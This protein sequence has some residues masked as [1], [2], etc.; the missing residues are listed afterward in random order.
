VSQADDKVLVRTVLAGSNAAYA[1]LYDRYA[2][3]VRAVCYDHTKHLADAQD[4]AQDVFLRAY[5]RLGELRK[6]ERFGPWLI[7][8]TRR[9]CQEWRRQTSRERRR[10]GALEAGSTGTGDTTGHTENGQLLRLI[11]ML[12]ENERLALHAFYL[13]SQSVEDARGVLGLS[14]SGFY[15]VLERARNRLR[16]QWHEDQENIR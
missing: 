13:R 12:P 16:K 8:I 6:P 15:R 3:L 9:R 2:P 11:E 5:E 7:G 1:R 10:F 14:R 4:L